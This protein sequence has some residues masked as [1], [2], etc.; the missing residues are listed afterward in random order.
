MK[1]RLLAMVLTLT[2]L[3]GLLPTAALAA[4][5]SPE[6]SAD[7]NTLTSWQGVFGSD[8]L[9]TKDVGRIW[10]D[11]TVS[12]E[13]MSLD[14]DIGKKVTIE[15]EADADFQVALSALGSAAEITDTTK[16]PTD[17]V[18]V[19]DLSNN[20]WDDIDSMISAANDAIRTLMNANPQ[21]RVAVVGYSTTSQVLLPLGHYLPG[22]NFL[23][24]SDDR[25]TMTATRDD[26]SGTQHTASFDR[27]TNSHKY[28][29][30]GIYEGM[31]I[32]LEE[33]NTTA[34]VGGATV[35]RAPVL[36]LMAEGEAKYGHT[37]IIAPEQKA[38][39]EED[40]QRAS[41]RYAQSWVAAMTAAYMKEQVTEHY[42]GD[43]EADHSA[44][45]YT[46]GVDIKGCDAP[47]LA[48]AYL[49]PA[50]TVPG[51]FTENGGDKVNPTAT[52][53]LN[54][55]KEKV[56]D[57]NNGGAE[58][59]RKSYS[60]GSDVAGS[61][62][63]AY[64]YKSENNNVTVESI[65]YND[66]YYDVESA[67]WDEIFSQIA[68]D[69]SHQAP[70]MPTNVGVEGSGGESGKLIFTDTLGTYME[71]VGLPTIVFA[72]QQFKANENPTTSG[73]TT[74]YS[75][76]GKVSGNPVYG[77]ADLSA[78][79]LKIT[80]DGDQQTL[81]WE[82]PA[83][84]LPLRTMKVD[85]DT[86]EEGNTSYTIQEENPAYPIRL[87]YSVQKADNIQFGASDN[88]YL[89]ANTV[90]GVTSYYEAAWDNEADRGGTTAVF[91]PAE[92]NDFYHY[93][94][95]TPLY[96]FQAQDGRVL[97][98]QQAINNNLDTIL[99]EVAAAGRVQVERTTYN[100]TRATG[101][102]NTSY[103]Y[104]YPHTY[105][106]A[107]PGGTGNEAE[108]LTD[109][110]RV[111]NTANMTQDTVASDQGGLYVKSGVNKMSR[112]SDV[113]VAKTQNTTETASTV[114]DPEYKLNDGA[115]VTI[116]L[117][118]NGLL[119]EKAPTGSLS[120]T[121]G[122][123]TGD[124]ASQEQEFTYDIG[125]YGPNGETPEGDPNYTDLAGEYS[126]TI[127]NLE[128]PESTKN[129]RW[130]SS[131]EATQ[132]I[133][134]GK[135]DT[136]KIEGLP[137]G[138]A[139]Q[140]TQDN[141]PGYVPSYSMDGQEESAQTGQ[142]LYAGA[143]VSLD[144]S[145]TVT[146]AYDTTHVSYA[147]S[148][149]ANAVTGTTSN[150]PS[151]GSANGGAEVTLAS[152]MTHGPVEGKNVIFLG[153]YDGEPTAV[154][155][156]YGKSVEDK[157][158]FQGVKDAKIES[159]DNRSR[160]IAKPESSE[161]TFTMP[162][163]NVTLYAVWGY[164]E[165]NNGTADVEEELY[166]LT[167][168][169][170][171]GYFGEQ[172]EEKTQ[173]KVDGLL[174]QGSYSLDYNPDNI[175]KRAAGDDGTRY[176]FIAWSTTKD[177]KIYVFGDTYTGGANAVTI[178]GEGQEEGTTVYAVWGVDTDGDGTADIR[179]GTYTI[180]ASAGEGGSIS[181]SGKVSVMAGTDQT[182][183]I[184]PSDGKAV[185]TIMIQTLSTTGDQV[186]NTITYTNNG[187]NNPQLPEGQSFEEWKFVDVQNPFSIKVTF[188]DTSGEGENPIPDKYNRTITF[189]A[190]GGYFDGDKGT[191]SKTVTKSD[192]DSLLTGVTN[193]MHDD[194][195]SG[196]E[197]TEVVFQGW[198]TTDTEEAI[199]TENA[200]DLPELVTSG[201]VNGDETLYAVWVYSTEGGEDPAPEP[202]QTYTLTYDDNGGFGGPGAVT[203]EAEKTED[204]ELE[205]T[206]VPKHQPN[207]TD[208]TKI[209]FIGWSTSK[210]NTIYGAAD[211]EPTDI[212]KKLDLTR[213]TTVYAVWGYDANENDTPDVEEQGKY[214]LIY[215]GNAMDGDT[216]EGVPS[217]DNQKFVSGQTVVL[218]TE[219]PT[220]ILTTAETEEEPT[221]DPTTV[222]ST[223]E[224][225][226]GPADESGE[227]SGEDE[228]SG[229]GDADDPAEETKDEEGTTDKDAEGTGEPAP[230]GGTNP[231]EEPTS[232]NGTVAASIGATFLSYRSGGDGSGTKVVFIGWS[233]E[234]TN[235]IYSE[236]DKSEFANVKIVPAVTF[237]NKNITVYAVWG[238]DS[239]EDG[240][241]DVLGEDY[242]IRP[243]AGPNGSITPDEA[244]TVAKGESQAFT[245]DPDEDYAVD[246]IVIDGKRYVN[247]GNLALE[248]YNADAKT[249]TFEDVDA[250]HSITVTFSTDTDGD[251]VPDKWEDPTKPDPGVGEYNVTARVEGSG[252]NIDPANATVNAGDDVVFT[253][254]AN[255]GYALDYITVDGTV[256]YANNDPAKSFK[257][258]WTLENV[259]KNCEVVVYFGEDK[260]GGTEGGDGVPDKPTYLT[261]TAQAGE[262]GAISPSGSMLVK[263]G[264]NQSFSI[265]AD[266]NYHISDVVVNGA[267]VG[268]V[269]SYEMTNISENMTIM[270]SFARDSS[271]GGGSHT[272]R[273]TITASAGKGGEISPDGS[274][275]VT[276]GSDKT[277]T[278]TPDEGYVIEKVLV[279]GENVGAVEQYTFKN[280][281]EKHTIK[282][283]FAKESGGVADPDNTGVS[284]WLN[285]KDHSAYLGGYGG[286]RFG[287]D[288]NMTRAQVAQMFYNLLLDKDVP[289]TVTFSDVASDAWYAEAVQTLGSLGIIAGIG[290]GQFAP[291]RAIT[292]A[293]FTVIAMRFAELD[294]SG[295]NIF[296]D[297]SEDDWFYDYVVG[298]IKY[299]WITGYSDGRF[300]PYD[301]ITRAQVTTIVNRMLDRS[302]D[303][304]YVD[305]HADKLEQFT[306][307]PDTH[308]AYY[309]VAEATNTHDYE[310]TNSG[311]DWT[312]LQ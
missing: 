248:G 49:D 200:E 306:D 212:I 17:T 190:N 116:Y 168:D 220:Y 241:A 193:P 106:Q 35:T 159:E 191:T 121:V 151:P 43:G 66:Q 300:G 281:R 103:A 154:N 195:D 304:A 135:G 211:T 176:A 115:T 258:T 127:S 11:K 76:A 284:G 1:R 139:W 63:S 26:A 42:Y 21:N 203:V 4:G 263:C 142:V 6:P 208:G 156:I 247:N 312:G 41:S 299:G 67:N 39:I 226:D 217:T 133:T 99:P 126:Y 286:G 2:M 71:I 107:R 102:V 257:G 166:T 210:H 29:Q 202:G 186:T 65:E 298:A 14:G 37:K 38:D 290:N 262:N 53:A 91:T 179:E 70:S 140:I 68:D 20:M 36:I 311:E 136:L 84:L 122:E 56:K 194:V 87:F 19:L 219:G 30:R 252:G 198:T 250:D 81:T 218:D 291:D 177:E 188:A 278:I 79:T 163:R 124:G 89:L 44:R 114:R 173:N 279:D 47:A 197:T 7:P 302:A 206:N 119:K 165:N 23:T 303:K 243:Y 289:I 145:I 307:V 295:E 234:K 123:I 54:Y 128:T 157:E 229:A 152:D 294:T 101:E 132:K 245:F 148:Y 305:R 271:G 214:T 255:S 223:I 74:T 246:V 239:D 147:Y 240:R 237:D 256:V 308:W 111:Q 254:T 57:Y 94:E 137:A 282:A 189:D 105:Y 51:N 112:V 288:D 75:F 184:S 55:F 232:V 153:W 134:L 277:F 269:G 233:T 174:A 130:N 8:T 171:G 222:E 172:S 261:V 310:R 236:E 183:T 264:N 155:R 98:T 78:I 244:T 209:I 215:N 28:T 9:S 27:I 178:G 24:R 34:T 160:F 97:T 169:A 58:L 292:R 150:P 59:Y 22:S 221:G 182:F 46:M 201:T 167:Y 213:D 227:P 199:Y 204:Y 96:V 60:G 259:Q 77:D 69:V 85:S 92:S 275:R 231:T 64:I 117:G 143:P 175:P 131:D 15:K 13:S 45:I 225:A 296:T 18:F 73:N 287:P 141:V 61:W 125:L 80:Q 251:G 273:Y 205:S 129:G 95:N 267:S 230:T 265:T 276:R 249:Y 16:V 280:V 32:L 187:K 72:G 185:D 50:Q 48:Y 266:S 283:I 86:N 235:K 253:I 33:E 144:K 31:Y 242:V 216:A 228:G 113:K 52:W 118:N 301:T 164:D 181:P 285:T 309:E 274:V 260:T 238:Y 161:M 104:Y 138:T 88:D 268:A 192:G 108:K 162:A 149:D 158:A 196:K 100:L 293:E 120:L 224:P 297:V 272:T 110:H 170:N 90:D 12:T 25:L 62:G 10:V 270:A 109:Y 146:N 82:I 207:E 5:D 40:G 93:T 83:S 3:M 180:S